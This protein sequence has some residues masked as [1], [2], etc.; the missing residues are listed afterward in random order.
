MCAGGGGA[1]RRAGWQ[2]GGGGGGRAGER[3]GGRQARGVGEQAGGPVGWS[4]DCIG[5]NI[6]IVSKIQPY[7]VRC[8]LKGTLETGTT[9]G[10]LI[11]AARA[12][13]GRG[14]L[15]LWATRLRAATRA[16]AELPLQCIS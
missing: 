4:M 3:A 7:H 5:S 11:T 12:A 16:D 15:F 14:A 10:G 2:A 9:R 1:G 13:V 6:L 8:P